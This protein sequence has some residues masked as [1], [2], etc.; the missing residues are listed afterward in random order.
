MT[1]ATATSTKP[2]SGGAGAQVTAAVMAVGAGM[3]GAVGVAAI[4]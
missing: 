4:L 2:S 3:M 1:A